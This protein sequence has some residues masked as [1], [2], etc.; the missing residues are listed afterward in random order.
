[1]ALEDLKDKLSEEWASTY[2]RLQENSTFIQLQERYYALPPT[3]QKAVTIA[4][5][6]CSVMFAFWIP[7]GIYSSSDEKIAE[8]ERQKTLI[9]QMFQAKRDSS[10][11]VGDQRRISSEELV[12]MIQGR[13]GTIRLAPDQLK[14]VQ[15]FNSSSGKPS[16]AIPNGIEQTGAAVNIAKLNLQQIVDIAYSLQTLSTNVKMVGMEVLAA[17]DDARYFDVTFKMVNFSAPEVKEPATAGG[18]G[19]GKERPPAKPKK[20]DE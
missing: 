13:V 15:P 8:F 5:I 1:M 14:G 12:T 17:A 3:G 2:A 6:I 16:A 18:K 10:T 11:I 7:W 9:Q 20:E 4:G 19:S